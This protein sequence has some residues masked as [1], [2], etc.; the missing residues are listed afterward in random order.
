M[1]KNTNIKINPT[2]RESDPNRQ[3]QMHRTVPT[4]APNIRPRFGFVRQQTQRRY[5]PK[6]AVLRLTRRYTPRGF[7]PQ[8]DVRKPNEHG[9]RRLRHDFQGWGRPLSQFP[10]G[11]RGW[12]VRIKRFR[13]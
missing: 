1:S 3:A 8:Q 7:K 6:D 5:E 9:K 4:R 13:Y 11:F 12:E 2:S 10:A